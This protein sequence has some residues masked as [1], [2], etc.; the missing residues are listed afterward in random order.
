MH[1]VPLGFFD[2]FGRN[3]SC[4]PSKELGLVLLSLLYFV[5]EIQLGEL[6]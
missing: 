1:L 3:K 4:F 5:R 6:S 2:Y